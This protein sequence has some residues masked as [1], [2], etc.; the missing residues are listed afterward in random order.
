MLQVQITRNTLSRTYCGNAATI[1]DQVKEEVDYFL[2]LA[3]EFYKVDATDTKQKMTDYYNK[4][5][6]DV[7]DKPDRRQKI[8]DDTKTESI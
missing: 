3:S 8:D 1:E 4:L 7:Q 5:F 2:R 6:E